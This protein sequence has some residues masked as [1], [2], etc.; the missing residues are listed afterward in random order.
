MERTRNLQGL[1]ILVALVAL[2]ALYLWQNRSPAVTVSVPAST[3]TPFGTPREAWQ[4]ALE[5]QLASAGTPLPTPDLGTP[6]VPPTLPPS[7]EPANVEPIQPAQIV[8]TP[9]PSPTP[10]PTDAVPLV[11]DFGPSPFPSPTGLAVSAAQ[12]TLNY[13]PPQMQ[14]QPSAHVN[15]HYW[16]ERPIDAKANS[17]SLYYYTFGSDGPNDDY[18]VHHGVDMPNPTGQPIRA[19]GSGTVIF[20]GDGAGVVDR[21]LGDIYPAYGLLVIVRH[22]F[23]YRGQPIYTLYAHMAAVLANQGDRVEAGSVL[24]LSGGTGDVSGPHVHMEVRIGE[25]SYFAVYNPLL[26]IKPWVGHGVI[27]GTVTSENGNYL[28]DVVVTLTQHGRVVQTTTTYINPKRTP[29]QARDW[30][31]VPDPAWRENFVIGDVPAGEYQIS[32]EINGRTYRRTINVAAGTTNF[33]TLGPETAATPQ[34]VSTGAP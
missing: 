33:V 12:A 3:A 30:E 18:R 8:I 16:L 9:W 6:F 2:G 15:D 13:Q 19:A 27:A 17:A 21:S 31:V 25:N 29:D 10:L 22:D 24:G 5:A 11:A 32:V 14:G 26:W 7:V 4:S 1:V 34:P 23:S 20:A 28:D